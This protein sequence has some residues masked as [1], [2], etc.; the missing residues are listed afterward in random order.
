VTPADKSLAGDF[1]VTFRAE[2]PQSRDSIEYRVTVMTSTL[3]GIVGIAVV[4]DSPRYREALEADDAAGYLRGLQA[5][6]YATDPH[7]ADKILAILERGLP[8]TAPGP[9]RAAQVSPAPADNGADG[10]A[11]A[12]AAGLRGFM[13]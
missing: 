11:V 3:W 7:Y 1:M 4:A 2:S 12:L 13:P 6:G 10:T 8:E 9:F 5:G